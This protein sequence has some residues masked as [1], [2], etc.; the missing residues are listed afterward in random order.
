M[1]TVEYTALRTQLHNRRKRLEKSIDRIPNPENL[2]SLLKEVD[3]ALER[4]DQGVYGLCEVCHETIEP[5]RLLVDPLINVC[6]DHLNHT[7]QKMLEHDLELA[8]KIQRALLPENNLKINGW[9]ISYHYQ[10]VGA[11]SGDYC[12]LI[13]KAD[14]GEFLFLLGDVSGKGIPAS[15]L[16]SHLHALFH[17]LNNFNLSVNSMV[18]EAN[19]LFC[20]STIS[21]YYAT[22][23]CGKA[24][25]SGE[26]EICNAGHCM[27]L[28]LRE[29]KVTQLESTGL[30][31]GLFCSGEY[32]VEKIVLNSGDSLIIYSDGL[33]EAFHGEVPYS[34]ERV[35][36]VA[37]NHYP[38][39]PGELINA[40]LE[41]LASFI[42]DTPQ[43]D[44]LTIMVIR[45][46]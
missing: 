36:E 25:A 8:A 29:G 42:L 4:M 17:S 41:D 2:V 27:P 18:E 11:V 3:S 24:T 10:P 20:Q 21:S 46:L 22:L 12:D 9:D 45:R 14:K 43:S 19:R 34:E 26:V 30:P 13:N 38:F 28:L 33:S 35:I 23:V 44:D 40:Y 5:E 39:T 32:G 31:I 7:Q 1:E 15:M 6:L 37:E 16:M